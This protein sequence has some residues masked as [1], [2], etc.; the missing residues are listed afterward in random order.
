[1]FTLVDNNFENQKTSISEINLIHTSR[2]TAENYIEQ[3]WSSI[4]PSPCSW[5]RNVPE[6]EIKQERRPQLEM[7]NI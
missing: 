6:T 1:M 7:K 4:I 3:A 2:T 5:S